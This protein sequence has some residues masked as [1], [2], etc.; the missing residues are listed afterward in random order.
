MVGV[1]NWIDVDV[2]LTFNF[3]DDFE[4]T[5]SQCLKRFGFFNIIPHCTQHWTITH[6]TITIELRY[7]QE[8]LAGMM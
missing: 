8:Y 4:L 6:K 7:W 2:L 1:F 3:D 5:F